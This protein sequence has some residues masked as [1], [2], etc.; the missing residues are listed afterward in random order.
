MSF[1]ITVL[2]SS[3]ALPTST[4]FPTAQVLNVH[5][6]F[7][8]I[9]CGEGAQMQLRR[10]SINMSKIN[11]IFIS[12]LHGDHIFG[13][14]GLFSSYNLMGRKADLHVYAHKDLT[15]T[16]DHFTGHFGVEMSY[17]I[18]FHAISASQPAQIYEDK[19]ITVETVPLRHSIPVNGFIF[20]EKQ[21]LLNIKKEMIIKYNLGIKDIRNIKEGRDYITPE[22]EVLSNTLLTLPPFK[23]RSYAFCTDTKYFTRLNA[24]LQNIDL[25]YF[26]AT[27]SEKDRKL[28]KETGHS[29][30]KQAATIAM[31]SN[32]GKLLIGHFSSRY[33]NISLLVDEARE[34]FPNTFAAEDCKNYSIEKIRLTLR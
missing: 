21:Q 15:A 23:P 24:S 16:L 31:Q 29:T 7:F 8:L 22:G 33:K 14:F 20:R 28:A 11:N 18:V 1:T 32:A 9:D 30:A 5:E 2:G 6:R 12:H 19:H 3:S 26:E 10:A 4:R 34:I 25:L 17:N 13:L 27:F